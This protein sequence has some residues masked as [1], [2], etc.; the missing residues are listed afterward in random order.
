MIFLWW[1]AGG[2]GGGV[3]WGMRIR[4]SWHRLVAGYVRGGTWGLRTWGSG[5]LGSGGGGRVRGGYS[6][7]GVHGGYVGVRL[8][9]GT[10][11]RGYLG[12]GKG[13]WRCTPEEGFVR[14]VGFIGGT[15]E[16][17][18]CVC[19]SV[20]GGVGWGWLRVGGKLG[21]VHRGVCGEYVGWGQWMMEWR[22]QAQFLKSRNRLRARET[23]KR[24]EA[25]KVE[26]K[27]NKNW[28]RSKLNSKRSYVR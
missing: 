5:Y 26:Q 28:I 11:G 1:G 27:M 12:V 22:M 6:L 16:G 25:R 3:R 15:F 20:G 23:G 19:L 7:V 10:W 24:W 21:K 9:R 8:G 4:V 13:V 17:G 14:W 18:V 2:G